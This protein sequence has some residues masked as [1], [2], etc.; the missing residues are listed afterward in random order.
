[1]EPMEP[2]PAEPT[3]ETEPRCT[4]FYTAR[5]RRNLRRVNLWAPAAALAYVAAAAAQRWR[6]P[7]ARALPW[8][9]P[10]RA[11]RGFPWMPW[12]FAG[13]SALCTVQAVRS[14]LAFLREADELLRRIQTEALA[15][16][17]AAGAAFALI[18][19]LLE[20][21]GAPVFGGNGVFVVMMFSWSAGAWLGTRRYSRGGGA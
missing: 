15:L 11:L 14:Y 16:G 19:P 2:R 12:L 10:F 1:M 6:E 5:D 18:Y 21:L 20:Q 17:F 13:L 9:Q 3:P 8:L 7:L 4:G